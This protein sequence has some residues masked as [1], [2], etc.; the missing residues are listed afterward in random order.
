M[1]YKIAEYE[2]NGYHDSYWGVWV[3]NTDTNKVEQIETGSTAYYSREYPSYE[4]SLPSEYNSALRKYL[5]D[6][7]FQELVD[8]RDQVKVTYYSYSQG[9]KVE[10]S[11]TFKHKGKIYQKGTKFKVLGSNNFGGSYSSMQLEMENSEKI[12]T[13]AKN[14]K[15]G[16]SVKEMMK[17]AIEVAELKLK[18]FGG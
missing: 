13:S 2:N 5:R 6:E 11:R 18:V 8:K 12:F 7:Y 17:K 3:F 15:L 1:R 10:A 4:K 9:E 16:Y 14:L